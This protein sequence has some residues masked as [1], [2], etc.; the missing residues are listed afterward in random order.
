LWIASLIKRK[1]STRPALAYLRLVAPQGRPLVLYLWPPLEHVRYGR[2]VPGVPPPLDF[3]TVP[4]L[5]P[6]VATFRLVC[7]AM[8]SRVAA[9]GYTQDQ[10]TKN[11]RS[12]RDFRSTI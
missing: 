8:K 3:D 11:S 9:S 1:A 2:S 4:F 7:A 10:W 5:Y 12:L 6:L